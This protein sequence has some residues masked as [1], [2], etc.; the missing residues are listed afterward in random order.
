MPDEMTNHGVDR[1][2]LNERE[3]EHGT[4]SSSQSIDVAQFLDV[5]ASAFAQV[6]RLN[7]LV[8]LHFGVLQCFDQFGVVE[9]IPTDN[10][11]SHP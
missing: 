6:Q 5:L 3:V 8:H 10:S 4:A 1:G 2:H 9:N 11:A 7:D